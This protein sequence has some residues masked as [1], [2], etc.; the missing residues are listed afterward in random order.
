M[1]KKKRPEFD[2]AATFDQVMGD[3]FYEEFETSWSPFSGMTGSYVTVRKNGKK[4][5][6]EMVTYGRGVSDGIAAARLDV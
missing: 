6:K 1:A 4:L 3:R 2:Y 5:T